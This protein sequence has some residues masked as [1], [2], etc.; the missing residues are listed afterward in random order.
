MVNHPNRSK[1][2]MKPGKHDLGKG[3]AVE[4][5]PAMPSGA[6]ERMAFYNTDARLSDPVIVLDA[7]SIARLREAFRVS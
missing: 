2:A 6:P 3:W 1:R 4:Y 5:L 7:D